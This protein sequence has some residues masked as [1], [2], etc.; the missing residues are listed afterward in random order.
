MINS[1]WSI[2]LW[3]IFTTLGRLTYNNFICFKIF[4]QFKGTGCPNKHEHEISRLFQK[5]TNYNCTIPHKHII[6]HF[7]INFL[8]ISRPCL[9]G[10]LVVAGFRIQ[11]SQ[12][13]GSCILLKSWHLQ[14]SM[15]LMFRLA[16]YFT[17]FFCRLNEL[18]AFTW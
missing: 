6:D 13:G 1:F 18:F 10:H 11:N 15:G 8:Y 14:K 7:F 5:S 16:E 9:F 3:Y 17:T 12:I 4:A 2:I